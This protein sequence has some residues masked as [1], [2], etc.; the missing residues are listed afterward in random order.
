MNVNPQPQPVNGKLTSRQKIFNLL[1]AANGAW[2]PAPA[3]SRV[4]CAYTRAIHELRERGCVVENKL[5]WKDGEAHG[6]YRLLR[7]NPAK[8]AATEFWQ[9]PLPETAPE[10]NSLLRIEPQP[11][12]RWRDPE[13]SGRRRA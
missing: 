8:S 11:A 13:Q 4:C 6:S 9:G 12:T 5:E 10:Q 7:R 1:S 2:I 3:L